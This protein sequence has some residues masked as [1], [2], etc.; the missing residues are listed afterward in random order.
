MR[1][2]RANW[3]R[4]QNGEHSMLSQEGTRGEREGRPWKG[5]EELLWPFEWEESLFACLPACLRA[6]LPVSLQ[7]CLSVCLSVCL[8]VWKEGH[9]DWRRDAGGWMK[10]S[11]SIVSASSYEFGVLEVAPKYEENTR[12]SSQ[13]GTR[14]EREGRPSKGAEELLWPF[15]WEESLFACLRAGLPV[16]LQLCLSVCLCGRKDIGTGEET[17][18]IG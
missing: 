14:G 17:L 4:H 7:L 11:A 18:E 12:C 8:P 6:G 5:A 9:R 15:E 10:A 3:R 13:E 16:S 2:R 1:V